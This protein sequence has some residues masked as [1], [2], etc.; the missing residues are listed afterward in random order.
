MTG[1]SRVTEPVE[2]GRSREDRAIWGWRFGKGG[3]RISLIGGCHADEPVGPRL[4]RRLVGHL[5]G[6]ED[7]L[8]PDRA[9]LLE[10][11]EWWIVPH[12]NPDGEARNRVWQEGDPDAYDLPSYL[13]H[14]VRE[15]PGD[16][17]EFGFPRGGGDRGD[18][19]HAPEGP[20]PD[21]GGPRPENLALHDWWLTAEGAFHFHASLH[22]MGF[23]AGPWLLME[24][25]WAER[26]RPLREA[27]RQ[28]AHALGYVLHDVERL[29]EKGFF[30]LGRGFATRPDSRHMRDHFLAWGDEEMA[31]R[32]RPSSM[33]TIRALAG[34]VPGA[35]PL[36]LV[37][38]MPLFLTPGVGEELGPPDPAAAAWQDRIGGWRERVA[39]EGAMGNEIRAEVCEEARAAGLRPMPVL[40]Q[41]ALQWEAILQGIRLAEQ[42]RG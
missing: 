39:S 42:E 10:N 17:M 27:F 30:R 14:A 37:T 12:V 18:V 38:E 35:D 15:L 8:F 36:T 34:K 5:L 16:D 13:A 25:T 6:R 11:R 29:G 40:D 4:L 33:E 3:T 21:G 20:R 26:A 24:P 41:M 28:R 7:S 31:A 1:T 32:F 9:S 2:L 19:E 23:A 22:G